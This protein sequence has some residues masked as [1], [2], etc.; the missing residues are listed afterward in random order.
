MRILVFFS[1]Q[2]VATRASWHRA[3][4][5]G[6]AT[7]A[8]KWRKTDRLGR[9][10]TAATTIQFT[11]IRNPFRQAVHTKCRKIIINNRGLLINSAVTRQEWTDNAVTRRSII[12][13]H[14]L[15]RRRESCLGTIARRT[16]GR[17]IRD[18]GTTATSTVSLAVLRTC[19]MSS[20]CL[21][22]SCACEKKLFK[23]SFKFFTRIP[24]KITEFL[25]KF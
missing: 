23:N 1:F 17:N 24:G 10:A 12:R 9:A 5:A 3:R 15:E 13:W 7:R 11:E 6:V 2:E 22:K 8:Q 20:G 21:L 18:R 19:E 4:Q 14:L 16:R 25:D